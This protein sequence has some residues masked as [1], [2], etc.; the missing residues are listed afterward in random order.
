MNV[1]SSN[2]I[3][4]RLPKAV[5]RFLHGGDR[6][7]QKKLAWAIQAALVMAGCLPIYAF[8][9]DGAALQAP[10]NAQ[11]ASPGDQSQQQAGDAQAQKKGDK[12]KQVKNLGTVTVTGIVGSLNRTIDT[13]RSQTAI[14]DA[15]SAEDVGKFP[16]NN[17]AESL[18]RIT[19]V[20][21]TRNG[22]G[23]G[24]YV[25]VRGLP[26]DFTQVTLNGQVVSSIAAAGSFDV[27]GVNRTRSFDLSSMSPDFLS[28]LVVYKSSRADLPEGGIGAN[29]D[30]QTVTPFGIGKERALL[31]V[32]GQTS[33]GAGDNTRTYPDVTALYSNI[34]ADGTFGV[35]AGFDWNKRFVSSQA[36]HNYY[37]FT[38]VNPSNPATANQYSCPGGQTYSTAQENQAGNYPTKIDTKTAYLSLQ[39]KPFDSTT[40]TL[41]A[42]YSRR[43]ENQE[44]S[45][46]DQVPTGPW[47]ANVFVGTPGP[48][49]NLNVD[50]NGVVTYSVWDANWMVN[51]SQTVNARDTSK[52]LDLKVS[53]EVGNWKFEERALYSDSRSNFDVLFAQMS[54]GKAF[55]A[56]ANAPGGYQLFPNAPVL[57]YIV[58][59]GF[60]PSNANDPAWASDAMTYSGV[61]SSQKNKALSADITRSFDSPIESVKFGA[62]VSSNNVP[63][64][65]KNY[66]YDAIL[67]ASKGAPTP[68]NTAITSS[69][70]TT[71]I[72]SGYHG[73]GMRPENMFWINPTLLLNE[74]FGGS[75]NNLITSPYS[76][77]QAKNVDNTIHERNKSA[78][79]MANFGFDTAVPISGNV[80]VRYVNTATAIN[81]IGFTLADVLV[82][83]QCN[84]NQACSA[85]LF[86]PTAN[87][88]GR[89]GYHSFLPSLNLIADLSDDMILRF[90][91]SK[92]MA[93]PGYGYL[94]PSPSISPQT[95]GTSAGNAS[96]R[97]FTSINYDLSYE[98]YFH[99]SSV[100]SID[101]YD[102]QMHGFVQSIASYHT[103]NTVEGGTVQAQLT[104]PT[105][106]SNAYVRGVEADY[107]QVFDFLP[108]FWS[109]FGA[110][111]N[112]TYSKGQQSA[113]HRPAN[114][115]LPG[116][117]VPATPFPGLTKLTYNATLF[118]EKYG[119]SGLITLNH[120]DQYLNGL[121]LEPGI[122]TIGANAPYY[123][124]TKSRNEVDMQASYQI[125]KHFKVFVEAA[126]LLNKPYVQFKQRGGSSVQY[127]QAWSLNGRS[128]MFGGT[129]TF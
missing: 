10:Q 45:I 30:V 103:Y 36:T 87:V 104:S 7:E 102:K 126:N 6:R 108:S 114:G 46:F 25:S 2:T 98:W 29:V 49:Q 129:Y 117:D 17:V 57:G 61:R 58:G 66:Y 20:E 128:F 85:V 121:G 94:P 82:D 40:A 100:L 123:I 73:P 11:A 14:V 92:T 43:L 91:T 89:G 28:S 119:F 67:A 118:Y 72:L 54:T 80:G 8:A 84:H 33:S 68:F 95:F 124:Y 47:G 101:L 34:F 78:Y 115:N 74:Y 56:A 110:E 96:L 97:P 64:Q 15:V 21:I 116:L 99:P 18:Q 127:P 53:T 4:K 37:D 59:P 111:F 90:S 55:G 93:R 12:N 22:Q 1:R 65:V 13:K 83:P 79:V 23:E 42:L 122:L 86:P 27:R 32:K 24:Q 112:V 88:V 125:N 70:S 52:N 71:N 51:R 31:T 19:G 16:D 50:Q 69:D 5:D 41:N 44:D 39:W 107:K 76:R 62:S 113:Y 106:A 81:Y 48:G 60:N 75:V 77:S 109:G 63:T 26:S 35:T 38:C 3:S 105:N 120:R 9:A